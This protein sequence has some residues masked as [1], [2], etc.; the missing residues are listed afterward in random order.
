MEKEAIRVLKTTS[1][2][3]TPAIVNGKLVTSYTRKPVTFRVS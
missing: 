3:W 1:N 2:K